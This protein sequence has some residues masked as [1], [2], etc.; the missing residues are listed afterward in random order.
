LK[1]SNY[2][3]ELLTIGTPG[4][5]G[6]FDSRTGL[7]RPAGIA[8]DDAARE[9]YVADSGNHRIVV[10]DSNTGA[11]KRQWGGSGD[12]PTAA[13]A[14]AY[15][16][17]APAARQFRDP[18]CV[19][20]ARDGQVYV[21]DRTSNRIQVFKKD[22][23]FVK[24]MVIAKDT[25]GATTNIGSMPLNSSGSVWDIAF[26]SDAQQRWL[27]VADGH[28]KKIRIL[29]R[30]TLAEA[31]SVGGGG[32]QVGRFMTPGSV[33]VD[34]RG[35]LYTGEQHATKRVQKFAPAP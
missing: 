34:A 26:S 15:D 18:T 9:V 5:P 2:G 21:C 32:R 33:A 27:F 4:T 23:A 8:V 25:R 10:F 20:I 12:A 24:E 29:R 13:G 1:F 11:F 6:A 16:P 7:S 30:E 19:K 31:G 17:A 28:N 35:N 14:G 3:R 22:G